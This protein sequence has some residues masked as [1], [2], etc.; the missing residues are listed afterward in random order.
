MFSH[1]VSLPPTAEAHASYVGARLRVY[2]A[3]VHNRRP[4]APALS[5]VIAVSNQRDSQSVPGTPARE[6][7]IPWPNMDACADHMNFGSFMT[8]N[9]DVTASLRAAMARCE[10]LAQGERGT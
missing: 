2:V 6:R 3:G 8:R 9:I 5:P 10:A 4:A 1:P 7:V